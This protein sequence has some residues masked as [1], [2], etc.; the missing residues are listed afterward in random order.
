MLS[1]LRFVLFEMIIIDELRANESWKNNKLGVLKGL[2]VSFN[3]ASVFYVVTC[4]VL[5]AVSLHNN[6]W[7]LKPH[8]TIRFFFKLHEKSFW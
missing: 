6:L 3:Y 2:T 8:Y 1:W 5:D 7:S 4:F